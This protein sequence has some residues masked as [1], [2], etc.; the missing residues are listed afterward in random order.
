MPKS[1]GLSGGRRERAAVLHR[2]SEARFVDQARA[3]HVRLVHRQRALG[4]RAALAESR[5]VVAVRGR[6]DA[7]NPLAPEIDQDAIARAG[8]VAHI[9]GPGVLIDPRVGRADKARRAVG[10]EIVGARNQRD[11]PA[12]DRVRGRG[13]L[14]VAQHHRVHV[15]ALALAQA[16]IRGE[17]V[18]AAAKDR[19]ADRTAELVALERMR[20]RC[21]NSK[22]LRASSASSRKN[23]YA[24]PRY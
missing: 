2:A 14:R 6:L 16:L 8:V 19:A 21:L 18:R 11:Q 3:E 13:A 23:S 4:D 5:N 7:G 9:G 15:D 22:K 1:T 10:I 17:E 20:L 24:S 12:D